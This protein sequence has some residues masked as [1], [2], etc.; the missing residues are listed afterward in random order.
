[1]GGIRAQ[2]LIFKGFSGPFFAEAIDKAK[3]SALNAQY[4][5]CLY[6]V[7]NDAEQLGAVLKNNRELPK[8]AENFCITMRSHNGKWMD[9]NGRSNALMGRLLLEKNVSIAF[10]KP[11]GRIVLVLAR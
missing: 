1:M 9:R 3:Y 6:F 11:A 8:T 4:V 5:Q 2:H 10:A 7:V